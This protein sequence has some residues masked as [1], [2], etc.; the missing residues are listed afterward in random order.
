MALTP[1]SMYSLS[2]AYHARIRSRVSLLQYVGRSWATC[3]A[4]LTGLALRYAVPGSR[5]N[6]KAYQKET[7][8]CVA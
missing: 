7:T 4:D 8:R 2:G 3:W 1:D 5:A 6:T